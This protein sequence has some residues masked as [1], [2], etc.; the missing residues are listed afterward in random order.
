MS[1]P[2]S[3]PGSPAAAERRPAPAGEKAGLRKLMKAT[4]RAISPA[5]RG[6][7]SRLAAES[8]LSLPE[9]ARAR[10]LL[11]FLSMGEELS[12]ASLVDKALA[13]GKLV[14]VPRMERSPGEGDYLVFVPLLEDYRAWPRDRFGIPEP[15]SEA[16]GLSAEEL[17]AASV[18]VAVPG[19]AFDPAGGRLGR[20][21]GYYDR[22]LAAARAGAVRHGG[23][24]FA[25]GLCFAGQIVDQVPTDGR[26]QALDAVASEDGLFRT[27]RT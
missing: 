8:F 19:L 6:R 7:L 16:A 4:L 13:Q 15:P 2:L 18:L 12:T 10:I 11:A 21:K 23:S 1:R 22:F 17:G 5:E 25:C 9:Y 20:G 3:P 26:D 24:L 27:R 14:A